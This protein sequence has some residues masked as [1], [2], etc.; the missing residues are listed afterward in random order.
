ME[1]PE[2]GEATTHEDFDCH[3][4]ADQRGGDRF[5]RFLR[6]HAVGLIARETAHPSLLTTD[7]GFPEMWGYLQMFLDG[8]LVLLAAIGSRSGLLAV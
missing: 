4:A 5:A 7:R 1:P 8:L 2:S 3:R 6:L